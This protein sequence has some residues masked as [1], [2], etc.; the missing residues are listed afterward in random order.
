M[1]IRAYQ[2]GANKTTTA[3]VK[4]TVKKSSPIDEENAAFT[5]Y[6]I[7]GDPEL[8][9]YF[10][11]NLDYQ[12]NLLGDVLKEDA[13]L[14]AKAQEK[15][16]NFKGKSNTDGQIYTIKGGQLPS[17]EDA[18]DAE[19]IDAAM[20]G[21]RYANFFSGHD[22][23][24]EKGID[25][26]ISRIQDL[27]VG[28][29]K[30]S[31]NIKERDAAISSVLGDVAGKDKDLYPLV[32]SKIS[33]NTS[34]EL[35]S[36]MGNEYVRF[37][38]FI[39]P[40]DVFYS[41]FGKDDKFNPEKFKKGYA[42]LISSNKML[43][44]VNKNLAYDSLLAENPT[45]GIST[46]LNQEIKDNP[47]E[48]TSIALNLASAGYGLSGEPI[49]TTVA[50]VGSSLTE[51]AHDVSKDGLNTGDGV[52]LAVNIGLDAVSAAPW[53]GEL[54]KAIKISQTSSTLAKVLLK[55]MEVGNYLGPKRL[56][57][58]SVT[59][60]GRGALAASNAVA[61]GVPTTALIKDMIFDENTSPVDYVNDMKTFLQAGGG[62]TL[63]NAG[64]LFSSKKQSELMDEF[65]KAKKDLDPN[66]VSPVEAL[67]GDNLM[68]KAKAALRPEYYLKEAV[69]DGERAYTLPRAA[70]GG[71]SSAF[72]ASGDIVSQDDRLRTKYIKGDGFYGDVNRYVFSPQEQTESGHQAG[73]M[74]NYNFSNG[75]ALTMFDPASGASAASKALI[76]Y[77][78]PSDPYP[79]N[80]QIMIGDTL[81]Q[82]T[83]PIG[84]VARLRGGIIR[85]YIGTRGTGGFTT[86]VQSLPIYAMQ[87]FNYNS[88]ANKAR[89]LYDDQISG[90]YDSVFSDKPTLQT[91]SPSIKGMSYTQKNE[92]MK[93]ATIPQT[94]TTSDTR[95][96]AITNI[97]Q[98]DARNKMLSSIDNQDTS[99][100]LNSEMVAF[101]NDAKNTERRYSTDVS[102]S[103]QREKVANANMTNRLEAR[104]KYDQFM[105]DL[106]NSKTASNV[107]LVTG[108]FDQ[109][110]NPKM[111]EYKTVGKY[112]E[113]YNR[114]VK[115]KATITDFDN[116]YNRAISTDPEKAQDRQEAINILKENG[117]SMAD[118]AGYNY[119][120]TYGEEVNGV[121]TM[122]VNPFE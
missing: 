116:L 11:K 74:R 122:R 72:N 84:V 98:N 115:A 91:I 82:N 107:S 93:N 33:A 77:A 2:T 105:I 30:Y 20:A 6:D 10:N 79:Y 19:K 102:N 38:E 37:K 15:L 58:Y 96:N 12:T 97:M 47:L 90:R 118:L 28:A 35:L 113:A 60:L 56:A 109:Y 114:V 78:L 51:F 59:K 119:V 7:Y 13:E 9:M 62:L 40:K 61:V 66:Y 3:D 39:I 101:A 92:L 94:Q 26:E 87:Q 18:N 80:N 99:L 68:N 111:N 89:R 32:S 4:P 121:K 95:L 1:I 8:D 17:V 55:T 100:M 29:V 44:D 42:E 25:A 45:G 5:A 52:G 120:N 85:K 71:I 57:R 16:A 34:S 76:H 36:F 86:V 43:K 49:G 70:L 54:A 106:G 23:E 48:W 104:E 24:L 117:M 14:S 73:L 75:R 21:W 65:V 108:V 112:N 53:I 50:G 88:A 41:S 22:V 63:H 27:L 31:G 46:I 103:E 69:K 64:K 67:L 83:K 81:Y 110:V